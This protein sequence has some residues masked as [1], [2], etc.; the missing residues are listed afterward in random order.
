VFLSS[1]KN[2]GFLRSKGRRGDDSRPKPARKAAMRLLNDKVD[3]FGAG[4]KA[5]A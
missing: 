3:R 5:P 1:G 2:P 4:G